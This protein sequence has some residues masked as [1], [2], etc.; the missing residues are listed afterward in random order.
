M[1][2]STSTPDVCELIAFF[3]KATL[4]FRARPLVE[5]QVYL[6]LEVS[7]GSKTM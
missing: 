1:I 4:I 5:D 2:N 7:G 3:P 6:M